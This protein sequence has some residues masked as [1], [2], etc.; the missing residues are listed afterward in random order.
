M[1]ATTNVSKKRND[2]EP[3]VSIQDDTSST[4]TAEASEEARMTAITW[5]PSGA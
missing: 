5:L 3:T 4:A 2:V 1:A